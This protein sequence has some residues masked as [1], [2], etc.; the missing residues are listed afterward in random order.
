MFVILQDIKLKYENIIKWIQVNL[1]ELVLK[2]FF[3]FF[4]KTIYKIKVND[5][6][7]RY[8]FF[9]DIIYIYY[10]SLSFSFN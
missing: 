1:L 10:L 3:D 2:C 5:N 6:R 7:F 8:N 9:D 4:L